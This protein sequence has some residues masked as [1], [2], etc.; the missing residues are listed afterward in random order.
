MTITPLPVTAPSETVERLKQEYSSVRQRSLD[1]IADL[2]DADA[3]VQ[4]MPDASPA[5]WHMAHTSWFFETVILGSFLDHYTVFNER[6]AFLFNSYYEQ[7]GPRQPRPSRGMLT[8]PSLE[9]VTQ[10]RDHVDQ[11]MHRFFRSSDCTEKAAGLIELGL[12]HEMQHQ[13]LLLTD[14]LHLFSQNPLKPAFRIPEPLAIPNTPPASQTWQ[15]FEGGIVKIGHSGPDFAFDCEGPSHEQIIRPFRLASHPVTNR[16]WTTFIEDG[17]YQD[18]LHWLSDGWAI[19]Q[20]DNWNAPLY[21]GE[22]TDGWWSM[23][24]RGYQPVDMDAPVT[25]ISYFEADAYARWAGKRLPTEFEWEFA[26]K[27]TV[28]AGNFSE[29]DHLRPRRPS[30]DGIA[31]HQLFGDVWEWTSSPYIAYPGFKPAD[32]AVSEYNGKFMSGQLVLRGGSCATPLKQ[33][34]SSYRNFFYPHQ[35]WQ[36]SGLRLAEDIP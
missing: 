15:S 18:P 6:F 16:E 20:A 36:F 5:K 17:G 14:I 21:W 32:G 33:V 25:H 8:R 34:R 27:D 2:S 12:H 13:E 26:A 29:T 1:L 9:E 31:S 11:H 22:E 23:T 4:S 7:L 30:E 10:Y 28:I 19:V 3:T 24:L 35:R